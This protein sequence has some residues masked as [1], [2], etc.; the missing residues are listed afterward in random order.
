MSIEFYYNHH[1][2]GNVNYTC[3]GNFVLQANINYWGI[4]QPNIRYYLDWNFNFLYNPNP[5]N[6]YRIVFIL[7]SP[8]F[9]EFDVFGQALNPLNGLS[10]NRFDRHIRD[11]L[12]RLIQNNQQHNIYEITII[13]P[14]RYECDCS[15]FLNN[16]ISN[17]PL[18]QNTVINF[19]KDRNATNQIWRMLYNNHNGPNEEQF[20]IQYLNNNHFDAIVNCCTGKCVSQYKN[21]LTNLNGCNLNSFNDLKAM[22]RTTIF[23][24][25]LQNCYYCELNH[26]IAW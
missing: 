15:H 18:P 24:L 13:N 25:G 3:T 19:S 20:F 7:E 1:Y 2:L 4:V 9:S 11:I 14:V 16:M 12:Q 26:P 23:N 6:P 22:V 8:S 17:D 21:V 5:N 10:G